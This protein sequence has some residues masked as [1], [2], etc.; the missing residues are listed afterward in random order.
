MFQANY[1]RLH[2]S[3]ECGDSHRLKLRCMRTTDLGFREDGVRT[4]LGEGWPVKHVAATSETGGKRD[5]S[6]SSVG[7]LLLQRAWPGSG[8]NPTLLLVTWAPNAGKYFQFPRL[9][10]LTSTHRVC[11][12]SL[13][14]NMPAPNTCS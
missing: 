2:D 13:K 11:N 12:L 3:S 4:S 8:L 1:G 10:R 7:R 5:L 9:P 14:S 6:C